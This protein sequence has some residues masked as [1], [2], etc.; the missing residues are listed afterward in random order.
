[1]C[2]SGS[3]KCSKASLNAQ[4]MVLVIERTWAWWELKDV[5]SWR[6]WKTLVSQQQYIKQFQLLHIMHKPIET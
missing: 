1:M 4:N 5:K 3:S 2:G 6:L